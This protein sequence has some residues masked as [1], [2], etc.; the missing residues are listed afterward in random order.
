MSAFDIPDP[1]NAPPIGGGEGGVRSC[2]K[3]DT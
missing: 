3:Y 1:V 2:V